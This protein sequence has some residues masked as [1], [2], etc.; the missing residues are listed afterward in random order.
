MVTNIHY[1]SNYSPS[2]TIGSGT[3]GKMRPD[4]TKWEINCK[5]SFPSYNKI[6]YVQTLNYVSCVRVT[7]FLRF[8]NPLFLWEIF[9]VFYWFLKCSIT[10]VSCSSL[11]TYRS[12]DENRSHI[13]CIWYTRVA[14][15]IPTWFYSLIWWE[16]V[17]RI[18]AIQW[19]SL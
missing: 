5:I 15:M 14:H 2:T 10:H 6:H 7:A 16:E 12:C 8:Q 9:S 13:L 4:P 18:G 17:S 19:S 11:A 1:V 3:V